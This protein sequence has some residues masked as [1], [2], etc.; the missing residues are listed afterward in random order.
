MLYFHLLQSYR[1]YHSD[2]Y[3]ETNGLDSACGPM[4]WW[5]GSDPK[6]QKLNLDPQKRPQS[7]LTVFGGALSERDANKTPSKS[8]NGHHKNG[9]SS[10]KSETS[11]QPPAPQPQSNTVRYLAFVYVDLFVIVYIFICPLKAFSVTSNNG[12]QQ[13]F[14]KPNPRPRCVVKANAVTPPA[15]PIANKPQIQPR[16]RNIH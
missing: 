3:P 14:A 2:I 8:E 11:N 5:K 7:I 10:T 15:P 13:P 12:V 6:V 1:E 9:D 4:T 16:V